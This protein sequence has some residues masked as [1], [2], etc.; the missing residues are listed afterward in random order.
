MVANTNAAQQHSI[1]SVAV[2]SLLTIPYNLSLAVIPM[3]FTLVLVVSYYRELDM[4]KCL[5]TGPFI[6]IELYITQWWP[7]MSGLVL[8]MTLTIAWARFIPLLPVPP[9]TYIVNVLVPVVPTLLSHTDPSTIGLFCFLVQRLWLLNQYALCIRETRQE[10]A[11]QTQREEHGRECDAQLGTVVGE[12][13]AYQ[14]EGRAAR[15]RLREN[16]EKRIGECQRRIQA[17]DRRL[18]SCQQT[19]RELYKGFFSQADFSTMMSVLPFPLF[20]VGPNETISRMNLA[21]CLY[22]GIPWSTACGR[23]LS[24]FCPQPLRGKKLGFYEQVVFQADKAKTVTLN[25][26]YAPLGDGKQVY[27]CSTLPDSI[28]GCSL[29]T[30][31]LAWREYVKNTTQTTDFDPRRHSE[32]FR[33]AFLG[34]P[35]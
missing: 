21:A 18:E 20:V 5:F 10:Q 3:G 26:H 22:F 17:V 33:Q 29:P 16:A 4:A 1:I 34:S 15:K 8:L 28:R 30:K 2:L 6:A 31:R 23:P 19:N 9:S 12:L 14:A 24:G 7:T 25:C 11:R 35:R 32:E 27:M 13:Q